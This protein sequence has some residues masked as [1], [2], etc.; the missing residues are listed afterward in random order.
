MK[1]ITLLTFLLSIC[2]AT[3]QDIVI[4]QPLNVG[5]NALVSFE[6][7][8]GI[9]VYCADDFEITSPTVLGELDIFGSL[10]S[11]A[12]PVSNFT[13]LESM[14]VYIY[15]DLSGE[16][17]GDP[18]VPGSGIVELSEI[19]SSLFTLVED[20]IRRAEFLNIQLTDANG[21]NQITL[22]AGTYWLC[23]F[24]NVGEAFNTAGDNRW[25]WSGSTANVGTEPVLI[26]P[27]DQFGGG[28]TTW[29]NIST[30]IGS[31]FTGF[32]FQLRDEDLLS[33]DQNSLTDVNIYP[34]PASSVIN[35]QVPSNIE[36]NKVSLYDVLG[37]NTGATLVNGQINIADLA[38][39]VYL[40]SINT[41]A[42]TLTK[43]IVKQ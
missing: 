15:A 35:L 24:P 34:N 16:P 27:D 20:N 41:S 17:V 28:F 23:V 7:N 22:P 13:N 40:L 6:G 42:G 26:D 36:I 2:I 21:G 10:G 39:G 38:R 4:D 14:N 30:L 3:A 37:K 5:G 1:K 31:S 18:S 33:V 25:N 12:N 8:A 11:G 32:A 29:S 9:G 43:K 19:P